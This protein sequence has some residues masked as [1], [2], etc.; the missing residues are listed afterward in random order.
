[1]DNESGVGVAHASDFITVLDVARVR[2]CDLLL[3]MRSTG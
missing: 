1:M 3:K 2:Y